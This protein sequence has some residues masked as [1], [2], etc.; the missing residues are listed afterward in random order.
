MLD[1]GKPGE[2]GLLWERALTQDI[3]H[4]EAVYNYALYRWVSGITDDWAAVQAVLALSDDEQK[5]RL[6]ERLAML[7]QEDPEAQRSAEGQDLV[8]ARRIS[9]FVPG[10][11]YNE[12]FF[13]L[14]DI[15]V[16][17]HCDDT[18]FWLAEITQGM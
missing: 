13:E 7:R 1:I 16:F 3:G 18:T 15:A 12:N 4:P 8:T 11:L 14:S 5:T 6:V 17:N 9:F 2:A 10:A